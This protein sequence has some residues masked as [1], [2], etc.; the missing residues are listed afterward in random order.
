MKNLRHLTR[1]QPKKIDNAADAAQSE[2]LST[3]R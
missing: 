1:R 3:E 2:H